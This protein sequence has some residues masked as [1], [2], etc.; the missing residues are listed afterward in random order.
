MTLELAPNV[1]KRLLSD[2]QPL[3][4]LNQQLPRERMTAQ[5][6]SEVAE[7][8]ASA[9]Q[10][11]VAGARR[12]GRAW[13]QVSSDLA[14]CLEQS[15][16]LKV[17]SAALTA[18][19]SALPLLDT[20]HRVPLTG[21]YEWALVAIRE[22]AASPVSYPSYEAVDSLSLV[23]F[24]QA[25]SAAS[26]DELG[27]VTRVK[28]TFSV[29]SEDVGRWIGVTAQAVSLYERGRGRPSPGVADRLGRLVRLAETFSEILKPES[30]V[31]VFAHRQVPLL[32]GRTYR[33]ALDDEFIIDVLIDVARRGA[34]RQPETEAGAR[35]LSSSRVAAALAAFEAA[36]PNTESRAR[37]PATVSRAPR[38]S[39]AAS[40]LPQV[41]GRSRT[42]RAAA[43]SADLQSKKSEQQAGR[44]LGEPGGQSAVKKVA[45][46]K[47]TVRNHASSK[48]AVKKAASSKLVSSHSVAAARAARKLAESK[49]A[50]GKSSARRVASEAAPKSKK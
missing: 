29:S 30:V 4:L 44:P 8:F 19:L 17:N 31:P 9:L 32:A 18:R 28:L 14:K 23:R 27:P 35:Y 20:V 3:E 1:C 50:S 39:L 7:A 25:V 26:V 36:H 12:L 33:Q 45:A 38:A 24:M 49:P 10:G 16:G 11:N 15:A 40:A 13:R 41:P 5:N 21:L 47:T 37:R 34:G 42:S 46:A 48:S 22:L 6:E 43:R 2:Y